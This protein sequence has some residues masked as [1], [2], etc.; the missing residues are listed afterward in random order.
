MPVFLSGFTGGV[1]LHTAT[2]CPG[3]VTTRDTHS[4]DVF[5]DEAEAVALKRKHVF[6]AGLTADR[7]ASFHSCNDLLDLYL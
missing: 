6:A 4:P 5:D 7:A 1:T 2:C 3:V